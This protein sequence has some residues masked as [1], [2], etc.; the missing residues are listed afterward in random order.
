VDERTGEDIFTPPPALQITDRLTDLCGFA[1]ADH[2]SGPNFIHPIVKACILHFMV[3]YEHP[4]CDGNGRTA[5][6]IFY[7]FALRNGYGVFEYTAISELI[8]KGFARYPQ[9][10]VDSELDEGDL[11]YFVLYKLDIIRQS[12]DLLAKHIRN[13][14]DKIKRSESL[15]RLDKNLNLRQRL[16]LEHGLRHPHTEYTVKS[17]MNSNGIVAATARADLDDLVR[18]RLMVASKRGKQATYLL[19]PGLEA[20]LDRKTRGKATR[21]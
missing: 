11:T 5:R 19:S 21:R 16:L 10:Y 7:W 12:L 14:Q 6:A 3:G 8:R 17:H 1:N 20:R 4:F 18:R 9:A 15:L 13:E 2:G